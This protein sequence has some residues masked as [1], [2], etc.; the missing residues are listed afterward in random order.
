M[1]VLVQVCLRDKTTPAK[2]TLKACKNAQSVE[3]KSYNLGHF[4]P[5]VEPSFST[6]VADQIVF[7]DRV[8]LKKSVRTADRSAPVT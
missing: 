3:V 5:Y 6:I 8:T 4:E 7:L 2:A 1:P